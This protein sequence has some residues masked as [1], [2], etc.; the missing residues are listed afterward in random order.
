L[1]SQAHAQSTGNLPVLDALPAVDVIVLSLNRTTETMQTIANV[2]GQEGVDVRV[3]IVDQGS[4]RE[5]LARLREFCEGEPAVVLHEA[6]TNLGVGGGRNLASSFGRAE[7]IVG[8]DNDAIF[9]SRTALRH[10]VHRFALDPS[11]GAISFRIRVFATGDDDESSWA[12]A[13][14]LWSFREV[15]F[16][17]TTFV[18]AGHAIR[19]SAFEKSGAYDD[20]LFFCW[21]EPDLSE[22]M[23]RC[24]Y[25]IVYDPQ[26][27]VL[28]KISPEGRV[29]W[30]GDRYYYF[31]RNAIYV[32]FKRTRSVRSTVGVAAGYLVKG[33]YNGL[34]MQAIPGLFAAARMCFKIR[35]ERSGL[36]GILS[37]SP[38]VEHYRWDHDIRYRGSF[39][40][41]L[42]KRVLSKL[43]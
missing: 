7:V 24:G 8:I 14:G 31:A 25:S 22:R 23:L 34:P 17:A 3:W 13:D 9:K 26:V 27:E 12:F 28:H 6:G 41:R 33:L 20:S 30:S 36:K 10:V 18:G 19:R 42:R 29:D 35:K 37:L 5:H 43:G 16:L 15:E 1:S 2:L 39:T 40:H 32:H 4:K 11:L 38:E 21:E